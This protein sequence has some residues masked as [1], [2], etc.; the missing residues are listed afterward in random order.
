MRSDGHF[1]PF[2]S[3]VFL[4]L[5]VAWAALLVAPL[6]KAVKAQPVK[7]ASWIKEDKAPDRLPQIS[8]TT[9]PYR[10]DPP[11]QKAAVNTRPEASL[12]WSCEAIRQATAKLTSEQI[13]RLA[14]VYRLTDQQKAE[15]RRCLK[16]RT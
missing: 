14:R 7:T 12:P 6:P 11:V 4:S 15:A 8:V 2:I 5:G 10:L 3:A 9:I 1:I 16:E 13:A